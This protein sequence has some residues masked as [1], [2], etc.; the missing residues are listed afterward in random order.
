M[1]V[2]REASDSALIVHLKKC[3]VIKSQSERAKTYSIFCCSLPEMCLQTIRNWF[4]AENGR[5]RKQKEGGGK[6]VPP[7]G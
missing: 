7:R 1:A 3:S 2:E 6:E 5:R 4:H